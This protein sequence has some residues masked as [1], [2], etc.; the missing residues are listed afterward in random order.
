D[1]TGQKMLYS[2]YFG[3]TGS[4]QVN[5]IAVDSAGAAV[6][7]GVANSPNFPLVNVA[8]STPA[9]QGNAFIAKLNA[10][11]NQFV[12]STYI[13]SSSNAV[14]NAVTIDSHENTYVTGV[15]NADFSVT[16]GA[17]QGLR[18]TQSGAFVS[19]LTSSGTEIYT[20]L[21]A[22]GTSGSSGNS[23]AVDDRG[24]AY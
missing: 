14:G 6:V 10:Q 13:A 3:G 24:A 19:K 7:T 9:D 15:S 23:I 5:G 21:L 4:T 1:P 2:T 11:G 18:S 20:A 8:H 17:Y 16:R 22:N 12:F